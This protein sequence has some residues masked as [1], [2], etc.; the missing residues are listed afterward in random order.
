MASRQRRRR[1]S[2]MTSSRDYWR[3]MGGSRSF[4]RASSMS[5]LT[6]SAASISAMI[7]PSS[8]NAVTISSLSLLSKSSFH[9]NADLICSKA[10]LSTGVPSNKALRSVI[11][12]VTT[13]L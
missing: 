6:A 2:R 9:S 13:P 5:S 3:R 8:V 4:E 12:L 11:F 10:S 7:S 1:G